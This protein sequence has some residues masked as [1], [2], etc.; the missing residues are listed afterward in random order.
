MAT[1]DDGDTRK[2]RENLEN[3]SRCTQRLWVWDYLC[4]FGHYLQPFPNQRSRAQNVSFFVAHGVK[5][6]FEQDAY[7]SVLS[8]LSCLGG[9]ITAKCLWNPNYDGNVAMN[10]FLEA[11]YGKAAG[12]IRVYIDKLHDFAEREHIHVKLSAQPDSPHLNDDLL[13]DANLL[14]DQ[15]ETAAAD[16]PTTLQRVR[17][18]RM[19][20]DYAILERCRLQKLK[21]MPACEKLAHVAAARFNP[22]ADAFLQSPLTGLSEGPGL[23]KAAYL[24]NLAKDLGIPR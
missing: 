18:S 4:N 17:F 5:G 14:W 2:F 10:E 24:S 20:L 9:Y 1:C 8:E 23:D 11:Y 6:L 3:W 13:I 21:K 7:T 22:F 19:S 15:A 16:E 12:S